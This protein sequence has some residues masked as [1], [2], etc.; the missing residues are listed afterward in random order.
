MKTSYIH[1]NRFSTDRA[2][3][4]FSQPRLSAPPDEDSSQT[5]LTSSSQPNPQKSSTRL[6][7]LLLVCLSAFGYS[8]VDTLIGKPVPSFIP[9]NQVNNYTDQLTHAKGFACIFPVFAGFMICCFEVHRTYQLLVGLSAISVLLTALAIEQVSMQISVIGGALFYATN[10]GLWVAQTYMLI[11]WFKGK[12]LSF[13]LGTVYFANLMAGRPASNLYSFL[14]GTQYSSHLY[15]AMVFSVLT[16]FAVV[17]LNKLDMKAQAEEAVL[18]H[19]QILSNER[20]FCEDLRATKAITLVLMGATI[21]FSLADYTTVSLY[22]ARNVLKEAED[23]EKTVDRIKSVNTYLAI[24][25]FLVFGY[26]ADKKGKRITMMFLGFLMFFIANIGF[27]LADS[28]RNI[29]FLF[30]GISLMCISICLF[31]VS[32]WACLGLSCPKKVFGLVLS[33]TYATVNFV[34]WFRVYKYLS[35][36]LNITCLACVIACILGSIFVV[37]TWALNKKNGGK[38]DSMVLKDDEDLDDDRRSLLLRGSR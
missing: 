28:S 3:R 13:A 38:L 29:K 14:E 6:Q 4:P 19:S 36:D 32:C 27:F 2:T 33:L 26:L 1:K 30:G 15:I 24:M 37:L 31:Q 7:V 5:L 9:A 34:K 25:L 8:F 21:L 10:L 17:F 22:L 35:F 12:E 11:K 20:S 16:I 23:F 18:S